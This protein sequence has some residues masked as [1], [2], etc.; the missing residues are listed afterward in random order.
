MKILNGELSKVH[1]R[2]AG[3]FTLASFIDSY[4]FVIFGSDVN[5]SSYQKLHEFNCKYQFTKLP[6]GSWRDNQFPQP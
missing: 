6:R 4:V 3:D 2:K 5:E 1:F